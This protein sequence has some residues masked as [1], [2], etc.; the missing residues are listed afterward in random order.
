MKFTFISLFPQLIE[1][2]FK[3]SILLK[4][5]EK[6]LF[7]TYFVNPRD[8]SKNSYH[9]VDDYK[10]GGGA[11][12]LIQVEPLCEVLQNIKMKEKNSHFIF[13]TPS[14]KTFN[15][16]DA[17][18]L[19]IKKNIVFICGRYEGVDERVLELYANEV[20]SIGDFILTGGELPAL[21][22]CD[23][24]L[25]NVKGVLGN[26][27]SLEEESF[28]NALLEAPAFAKPFIFEKGN[29]KISAPS[30]FLKGNHARIASLKTT[31]ASCKT[32]FFRPDLFLEHERK[33]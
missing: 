14:G 27:Q 16:K 24:I 15:Q 33:K 28:E 6:G 19:S 31:L 5:Q 4:A 3:D 20:F 30:E 22:M 10:I 11:G 1:F 12:L 17:K 23:A 21:V 8:F 32:K 29:K 9:K 2:Y 26:I 7:Q 18:R 13:L 25:R